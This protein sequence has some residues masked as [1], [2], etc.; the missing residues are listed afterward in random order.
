MLIDKKIA[1]LFIFKIK[2]RVLFFLSWLFHHTHTSIMDFCIEVILTVHA[3]R[4]VGAGQLL[5]KQLT[6]IL[7]V[8]LLT[9]KS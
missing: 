7:P 4:P 9:K 8:F 5:R 2:S 1:D 3:T 6:A